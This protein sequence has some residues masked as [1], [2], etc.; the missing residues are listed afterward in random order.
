MNANNTRRSHHEIVSVGLKRNNV[1]QWNSVADSSVGIFLR[2]TAPS[3]PPGYYTDSS[4][5]VLYSK[6]FQLKNDYYFEGTFSST[7]NGAPSAAFSV[8]FS[9]E[10]LLRNI[11][12]RHPMEN[13]EITLFSGSGKGIAST[14]LFQCRIAPPPSMRR[15]G[16][17]SNVEHGNRQP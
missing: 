16:V 1:L 11:L 13:Y 12:H 4:K 8:F 9:A 5:T 10:K 2:E 17:R 14:G 15:A 6:P 7:E 3:N